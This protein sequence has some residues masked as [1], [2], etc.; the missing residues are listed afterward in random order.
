MIRVLV[1]LGLVAVTLRQAQAGVHFG[2]LILFSDLLRRL[3]Y[4]CYRGY[5]YY[6]GYSP[7]PQTTFLRYR[8]EI[9]E[10]MILPPTHCSLGNSEE[11]LR[12]F[13]LVN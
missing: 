7:A 5:P 8:P 6:R 1:A 11:Y 13:V 10:M 4:H 12:V 9:E 3:P 2:V